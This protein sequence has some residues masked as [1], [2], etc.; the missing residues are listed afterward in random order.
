MRY[1][2]SVLFLLAIG[3]TESKALLIGGPDIIDPPASVRDN[4]AVNVAQQGF[5]E[6]QDVLL[7]EDLDVDEAPGVCCG[8][9]IPAGETVNSHMIFLNVDGNE[10][11]DRKSTRLNSSHTD[12]SRMPSSA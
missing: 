4:G 5:N 10:A 8:A 9:P 7:E 3:P 11:V 6:R 12:I 1:V 2:I